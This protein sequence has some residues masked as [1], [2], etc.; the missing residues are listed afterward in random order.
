MWNF[1]LTKLSL[2]GKF[3]ACERNPPIK[4]ESI[5]IKSLMSA[6]I[7]VGCNDIVS[8]NQHANA[9]E[10]SK[11]RLQVLTWLMLQNNVSNQ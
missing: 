3:L 11:T 10:L 6:Q 9:R 5:P 4:V 2:S 8:E 1:L 7:T